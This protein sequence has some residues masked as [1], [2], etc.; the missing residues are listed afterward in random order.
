MTQRSSNGDATVPLPS[1]NFGAAY[2]TVKSNHA[3][4]LRRFSIWIMYFRQQMTRTTD[5]EGY[6][7]HANGPPARH[8]SLN[9]PELSDLVVCW[10]T[11]VGPIG[12]WI[13]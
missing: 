2:T 3:Q 13:A 12:I 10:R 1:T 9:V 7:H 11:F 8:Q 4:T 5:S 6:H